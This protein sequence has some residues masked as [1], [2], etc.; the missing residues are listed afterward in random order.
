M[1]MYQHLHVSD[2]ENQINITEAEMKCKELM[3]QYEKEIV[4]QQ[5]LVMKLQTDF[6]VAV[7]MHNEAR[8]ELEAE[9][10]KFCYDKFRVS[11]PS[12]GRF[13]SSQVNR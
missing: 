8:Q 2:E 1:E 13:Q 6:R 3:Y 7:Q 12:V 11:I 4:D 9:F 10:E 5:E